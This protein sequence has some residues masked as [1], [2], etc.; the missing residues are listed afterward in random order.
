VATSTEDLLAR[1]VP[2]VASQGAA[3][4]SS[5]ARKLAKYLARAWA[6]G[7]P[8]LASIGITVPPKVHAAALEAARASVDDE[9]GGFLDDAR[10]ALGDDKAFVELAKALA[11]SY[12]KALAKKRESQ[13][14]APA[15]KKRAS[16]RRQKVVVEE[17]GADEDDAPP[18]KS[19]ARRASSR[20]AKVV[21]EAEAPKADSEEL[22]VLE[23]PDDD[24]AP[25]TKP[26][27]I[28]MDDEP[29]KA[30]AKGSLP[31]RKK[32]KGEFNRIDLDVDGADGIELMAPMMSPLQ[33]AANA[34]EAA[35]NAPSADEG[36]DAAASRSVERYKKNGD[37]LE[38]NN[39]KKLYKVALEEA[40]KGPARA[41]ARAGVA[42]VYLLNGQNDEAKKHAEKALEENPLA[43]LA[44]SVLARAKRGEGTR[45]KLK[46][47]I[48]RARQALKG[49]DT[50][51]AGK[52]AAALDEAYPKEPWGQLIA[53]AITTLGKGE[54]DD[55]IKAAWERYPSAI[56]PDLAL[57]EGLDASVARAI[58]QRAT[59]TL[60]KG[61][62]DALIATQR[63]LEAKD[64]LYAGA[65]Q[66][67]LGVARTA[68]AARSDLSKT[69]EQDLRAAAGD[70]LVGLQYYDAAAATYDKAITLD[71]QSSI[72]FECKK[73]QER[74]SVLRRA[75]DK[76]GVKLKM[77]SFDGVGAAA[78][79]KA[80]G[81]RVAQA[82]SEKETEEKALFK[83][84]VEAVK[85]LAANPA[86]RASVEKRAAKAKLD[87][88]LAALAGVEQQ[89]SDLS[90]AKEAL[91]TKTPEKKGLFGRAFDKVKDTAKGATLAIQKGVL[92]GRKEEVFRAVA[93]ALR[94]APDDGWG[95]PVL[96]ELAARGSAVEARLEHLDDELLQAKKVV[97]KLAEL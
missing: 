29:P 19:V 22:P 61:G 23:V 60:E 52:E 31:D 42:L 75:F 67:A 12:V 53:I 16:S 32:E 89:L 17:L 77:G 97:S 39:A 86:R 96:D 54:P 94:D 2:K 81:G 95:D 27:G 43:A 34:A 87:N 37:P 63:N 11:Q 10:R 68:I 25:A 3:K 66:L 84:E 13:G 55:A 57:G 41:S 58:A 71:R 93:K 69:E 59:Y 18:A 15:V 49:G 79:K 35:K 40:P 5:F 20:R 7:L 90:Q 92:E 6:K 76:P 73:G 14:E 48:A 36:P 1:A 24:D 51:R 47:G 30:K 28:R 62:T 33:A 56:A 9:E 50:G 46:A 74:A 78:M 80:V 4:V 72:A 83:D 64:N 45:E 26:L 88:P 85:A 8:K 70:A 65:F 82:M 44:I 38:L 21:P 91:T